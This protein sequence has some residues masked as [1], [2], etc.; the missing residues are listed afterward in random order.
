MLINNDDSDLLVLTTSKAIHSG[1]IM[2]VSGILII[3]NLLRV[4]TLINI[5]LIEQ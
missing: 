3:A 1:F 5:M 4:L 2:I